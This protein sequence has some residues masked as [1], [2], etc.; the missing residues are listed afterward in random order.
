MREISH[1]TMIQFS[2][3]TKW[4]PDRGIGWF[5]Y[6][7]QRVTICATTRGVTTGDTNLTGFVVR[8]DPDKIKRKKLLPTSKRQ[9]TTIEEVSSVKQT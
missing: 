2:K 3:I 9:V 6:K 1:T 4:L 7:G 8:F 5:Y